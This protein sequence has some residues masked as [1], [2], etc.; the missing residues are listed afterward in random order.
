M[1]QPNID[2]ATYIQ[3]Q[4]DKLSLLQHDLQHNILN[5]YIETKKVQYKIY[6]LNNPNASVAPTFTELD[7][8]FKYTNPN[9]NNEIINIVE[10]NMQDYIKSTF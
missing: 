1:S 9:I 2:L 10:Q 7:I 6:K 8:I 5:N 3:E 4:I